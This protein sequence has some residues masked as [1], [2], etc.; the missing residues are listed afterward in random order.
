[1]GSIFPF[2][3]IPVVGS[4]NVSDAGI[5]LVYP[6]GF[7]YENP[8]TITVA[9][10]SDWVVNNDLGGLTDVYE[11][12]EIIRVG[13]LGSIEVL[14]TKF[15]YYDETRNVDVFEGI[16]PNGLSQ[17]TLVTVG[18]Y[19]N[20]LQMLYLSLNQSASSSPGE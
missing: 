18:N 8:H 3:Y 14:E 19:T 6:S 7:I 12:V 1:M 16:S 4:H 9:V 5:E 10:N 17:F 20:P 15:L 2:L 11:P 13:D